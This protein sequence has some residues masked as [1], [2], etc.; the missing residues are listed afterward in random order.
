[1]AS[2]IPT[3]DFTK[4]DEPKDEPKNEKGMFGVTYEVPMLL[5][6][7]QAA[8]APKSDEDSDED[9]KQLFEVTLV[10]YLDNNMV[11]ALYSKAEGFLVKVKF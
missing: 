4:K 3:I 5:Q 6:I 9:A 7:T 2:N 1:M 8:K 11:A 10:G